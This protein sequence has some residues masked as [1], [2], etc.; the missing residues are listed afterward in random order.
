MGRVHGLVGFRVFL[1]LELEL[2]FLAFMDSSKPRIVPLPGFDGLICLL[3]VVGV[4]M[5]PVGLFCSL[6]SVRV[7]AQ[8]LVDLATDGVG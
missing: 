6:G 7:K 3:E 8:F 5:E 2:Q 1:G 4:S